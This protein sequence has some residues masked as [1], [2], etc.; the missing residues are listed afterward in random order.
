MFCWLLR[1][2]G[3]YIVCSCTE[4]VHIVRDWIRLGAVFHFKRYINSDYCYY[5]IC[6]I[7]VN[8]KHIFTWTVYTVYI[9]QPSTPKEE[10]LF[11]K[12]RS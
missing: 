10:V 1:N 2:A 5:I 9:L 12:S 8:I 4:M 3:T 11:Q 7:V 6:N